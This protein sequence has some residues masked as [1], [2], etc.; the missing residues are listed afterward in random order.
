M[1]TRGALRDRYRI[2]RAIVSRDA[3]RQAC[4]SA[5]N[6]PSGEISFVSKSLAITA[7]NTQGEVTSQSHDTM[8]ILWL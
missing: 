3:D 4:A 5:R 6:P 2:S 1:D 7:N 8:T